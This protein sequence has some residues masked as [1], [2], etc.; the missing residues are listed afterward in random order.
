M[1]KSGLAAIP[2]ASG[3]SRIANRV[4]L[5]RS[6]LALALLFGGVLYGEGVP[7]SAGAGDDPSGEIQAKLDTQ[8][9]Q[10]RG[11]IASGR[12]A[13]AI[14]GL[15]AAQELAVQLAD[16]VHSSVVHG[17]LGQAY[18]LAGQ[19]DA[20][21][22]ALEHSLQLA[23]GARLIETE[24]AGLNDLGSL[25]LSEGQREQALRH[26]QHAVV[27]AQRA[28][29]PDIAAAASINAARSL[30]ER[31][32]PRRAA[33]WLGLARDALDRQAASPDKAM[34]LLALGRQ[35]AR[36][37]QAGEAITAYLEVEAL[38]T[39]LGDPRLQSQALGYRAEL[40]ETAARPTE[41]LELA[42]R[43]LFLAQ[44]ASAPDIAYL[45][46]WQIGRLL[47]ANGEID[48]A[49]AAYQQA[50]RTLDGLRPDLLALSAQRDRPIYRSTVAPVHLGLADL[51]LRRAAA[52]PDDQA[53]QA[54]LGAARLAIEA[55]RAAELEDYFRDQCVA[56]L[57]AR[58]KPLDRL[59]ANTA[60]LYPI[61]LPERTVM[62]LSLPAGL[63]QVPI[64]IPADQLTAEI[65]ELRLLLEKRTTNQYLP[66]AQ[67]LYDRLIRPVEPRLTAAGIDTLVLV[68][69]GPLRTIPLAALH[70]GERFLIDRYAIATGPG[71]DLI[72]PRPV[73]DTAI[74]PLL[75]GLTEGVQG[76]PPLPFVASELDEIAELHG[77]KVLEDH[78][79][80]VREVEESLARIPYSVVHIASHGE[81]ASDPEDSFLLTY[82]GK[83]DMDQLEQLIKLS[84]FRD[85]PIELLTLSAC[86]TAAG[87]DRA[88]LGLAGVAVKAGARSALATLWFIN[89]QAS[90]LLVT[91]FYR[92]LAATPTPSKAKALQLAQRAIKAD[93]RYRHPAYWSPFLLIGNW[94]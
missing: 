76:F 77:G 75:S 56:E 88:A 49:I 32:D 65:R 69:D 27:L 54:D 43:A 39:Q 19:H 61:I 67:L 52:Q 85:E 58:V 12:A 53:R 22:A 80:V 3:N 94:L 26:F 71:L 13:H 34:Q 29:R 17:L 81:F 84:R 57:Q 68:P 4:A 24:A 36:L 15:I 35:F 16:P 72:D 2:N 79:F 42:R 70:D 37:G 9:A 23:R 55:T 73:A 60:A 82:D 44:A 11:S 14:E 64:A 10:A 45:W 51:L 74:T 18:L 21:R 91:E 93:G 48:Q 92:Q 83:L 41:A 25:A 20:A 30:A 59:A 47:S 89:D 38:G 62:L 40:Y 5:S 1:F 31:N 46:T 7:A 87:D 90:S 28:S 6:T 33:S 50:V 63:A 8:L 86:R 78:Q 66:H